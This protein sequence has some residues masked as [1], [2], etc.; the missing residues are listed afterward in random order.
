MNLE[1]WGNKP[2]RAKS[3]KENPIKHDEFTSNANSILHKSD[4]FMNSK[5]KIN[6]DLTIWPKSTCRKMDVDGWIW[7]DG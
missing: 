7:K 4:Y 5:H 2:I 6:L 3:C 1:K